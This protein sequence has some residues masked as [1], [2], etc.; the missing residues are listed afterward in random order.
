M[1]SPN[2]PEAIWYVLPIKL[3]FT[4]IESPL[5]LDQGEFQYI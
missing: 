2:T 3:P 4:L 1:K 5:K